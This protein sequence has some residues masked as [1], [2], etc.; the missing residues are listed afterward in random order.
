MCD[1]VYDTQLHYASEA[2]KILQQLSSKFRHDNTDPRIFSLYL[3]FLINVTTMDRSVAWLGTAIKKY[4][5]CRI[6][7]VT[8]SNIKRNVY[9]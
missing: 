3:S 8:L 4:T 6:N 5:I 7:I 1:N 9:S 2:L